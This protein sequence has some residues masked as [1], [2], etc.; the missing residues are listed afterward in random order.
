MLQLYH[1]VDIFEVPIINHIS[2]KCVKLYLILTNFNRF[3]WKK[4]HVASCY[5]E[6]RSVPT[7]FAFQ[8]KLKLYTVI[9]LEINK[10]F[11]SRNK[12]KFK[13]GKG[14]NVTL[15]LCFFV[16]NI[17]FCFL[18]VK[19]IYCVVDVAGLDGILIFLHFVPS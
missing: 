3:A 17:I 12:S 13:Y 7:S 6:K 5:K 18:F 8:Y 11:G 4:N 10:P 2:C 1:H 19:Y 16:L 15:L 14:Q 9:F